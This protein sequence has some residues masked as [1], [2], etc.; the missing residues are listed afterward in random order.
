[1][2]IEIIIGFIAALISVW[3]VRSNYPKKDHAFWRMGLIIAALIY[4]AFA[5]YELNW[6]WLQI[7]LGGVLLFGAFALLSK[8]HSLIWLGIG[9]GLHIGWD[10]F[11]HSE[12]HP[13]FVPSWYPGACLGF[14]IV[15][16]VY[17]VRLYFE[18]R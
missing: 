17:I 7:E 16:A 15:I 6:S 1:M 12:G 4:V 14:D 13:G 2:I 11:L 8:R 5:L 10:I 18:R 3:L 9:W